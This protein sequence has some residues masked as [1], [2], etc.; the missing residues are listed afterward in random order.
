[1][2]Q[3]STKGTVTSSVAVIQAQDAECHL[4]V[5]VARVAFPKGTTHSEGGGVASGPAELTPLGE[6]VLSMESC[7]AHSNIMAFGEANVTEW[8]RGLDRR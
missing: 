7:G 5:G 1:M 2:S 6:G 4:A 3:P 8:Q